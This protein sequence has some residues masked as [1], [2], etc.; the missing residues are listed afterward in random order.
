MGSSAAP[1]AAALGTR[2]GRSVP[3]AIVESAGA[4]P[5]LGTIELPVRRTGTSVV[6][7]IA[8]PLNPLD[9]AHRLR[10]LPL[11]APRRALRAGQRVRRCRARVRHPRSVGTLVYGECH[12]S[13]S[14]APEPFATH[15][16]VAD[17]DLLA[18]PVA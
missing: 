2:S 1:A 12:A 5:R 13:P 9:L 18:L 4:A 10:D 8:A 11:D 17:E 15:V 16:L 6:A 7:V 3:A 14:T